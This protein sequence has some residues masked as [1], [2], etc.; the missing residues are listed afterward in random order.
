MKASH[1]CGSTADPR[2]TLTKEDA[3]NF[4]LVWVDPITDTERVPT[5]AGYGRVL[6]SAV[7]ST[8]DVPGWDNSAMDGYAIRHAELAV[9]GGRLRV[10]QRI[11]AGRVGAALEP[12]TAARIFTGAPVPAG[13]DT[14]VIQEVC[15]RAGETVIVPLDAKVG[16]NI[17]RAGEDIHS[18]VEVIAAGTRLAPQHLGLAASI[19][20][21][22]ICVHR[23]L[24]VAIL[25]SGDELA[26]PGEPLGP[27]QIYNSN[28]Y[29]LIGLLQS[30]GCEVVDLGIVADTL[31]AT[32]DAL[33]IGAREADL[34]VAS[35]GVS[36]GEEDHLKPAVERL[37][38]LDLWNIAMRPGKPV[39]FGRIGETPFFGSPGNPV[40]LFVTFCLFAR[41]IIL[42]M[43]GIH[44]DP[45]PRALKIRAGF[46][47]P[48]P[49]QRTEFHRARLETG[50]DGQTELTVYP[51]RSSAVLSSVAWADGLV[52]IAP[53]QRIQ[54]GDE[55][56]FI[57]FANLFQGFT[58][59][60][61]R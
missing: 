53:G 24:R 11:P 48:K 34:I 2:Q 59:E 35:G 19:G 57:P 45:R 15:A 39:A 22:E 32:M 16:A 58:Q 52:E 27:G 49:D 31:D 9:H 37:G 55:V 43:Q 25:A 21:A 42:K 51:S 46:D 8:I 44:G 60:A 3:I 1:D 29:T 14:V 13:A 36:V 54:R 20:A 6:A 12:G 50:E 38:T 5:A 7:T 10:A 18:G 28:R 56:D 23:R 61:S 33:R 26:T 4:L 47:W 17:R 41:P 40:S 30:L